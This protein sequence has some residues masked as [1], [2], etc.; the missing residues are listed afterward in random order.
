VTDSP[1]AVLSPCGLYRY[2]LRRDV[3]P[4]LWTFPSIEG[5]RVAELRGVVT[6]V[7]LNPSTADASK[8][9]QTVRKCISFARAAGAASLEVVN[10]Y[11]Y[12]ATNPRDLSAPGIDPVGPRNDEYIR[13][14]V[15]SAA[16]VVCGWG[17]N[18][19]PGI[20]VRVKAVLGILEECGRAPMCLGVTRFGDPLHPLYLAKTRRPVGL[21]EARA[22]L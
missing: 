20:A 17:Q 9:D 10:L 18:K 8:D 2:V 13:E 15:R 14:S 1:R 11:G 3:D 4:I 5:F 12:R 19:A 7:M 21:F 6:F 22:A 16:V